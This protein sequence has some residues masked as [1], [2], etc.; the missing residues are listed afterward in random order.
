MEKVKTECAG[1]FG[2]A[3]PGTLPKRDAVNRCALGLSPNPG[4]P[5]LSH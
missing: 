1:V 3:E 4:L 5:V 2:N